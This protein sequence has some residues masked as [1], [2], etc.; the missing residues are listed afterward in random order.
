MFDVFEGS[1]EVVCK[2]EGSSARPGIEDTLRFGKFLRTR[3][4]VGL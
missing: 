3:C 4:P 2:L 1:F